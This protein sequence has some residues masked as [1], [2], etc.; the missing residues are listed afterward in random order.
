MWRRHGSEMDLI[1]SSESLT[2]E[3][4]GIT[5]GVAA[6]VRWMHT[7]IVPLNPTVFGPATEENLA[8]IA[9]R[10]KWWVALL[11][12]RSPLAAHNA[13]VMP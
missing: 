11:V 12:Q 5:S 7:T 13:L 8:T 2:A 9:A 3:V 10:A 4:S 6:F 1:A